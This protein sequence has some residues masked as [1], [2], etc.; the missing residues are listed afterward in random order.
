MAYTKRIIHSDGSGLFEDDSALSQRARGVTEWFDKY[1]N[2]VNHM[3]WPSQSP[4][5]NPIEHLWEILDQR[6][7]QRSPPPSSKH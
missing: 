5:L 3:L 4:D 6:V 1:E 2:N 7:R